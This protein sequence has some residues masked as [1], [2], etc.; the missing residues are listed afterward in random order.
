MTSELW[1]L[2][3]EGAIQMIITFLTTTVSPSGN[4]IFADVLLEAATHLVV[5]L[6]LCDHWES[7]TALPLR[8]CGLLLGAIPVEVADWQT[9]DIDILAFFHYV[10]H[11]DPEVLGSRGTPLSIVSQFIVFHQ[12][13]GR[14]KGSS[15]C[16]TVFVCFVV[17]FG[18]LNGEVTLPVSFD[19][20]ETD[21]KHKAL[22]SWV[23][24]IVK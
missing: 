21:W 1:T 3:N 15:L 9:V 16:N 22:T 20:T 12:V 18:L 5:P 17:M 4:D 2:F 23:S 7:N 24:W 10:C 19:A 6:A 14:R 11:T 13:P 8:S